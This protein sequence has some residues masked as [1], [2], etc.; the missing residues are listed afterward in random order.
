M[1][2]VSQKKS[3]HDI[4]F[5]F[6]KMIGGALTDT[7]KVEMINKICKKINTKFFVLEQKYSIRIKLKPLDTKFC[8]RTNPVISVP[9][10]LTVDNPHYGIPPTP[11]ITTVAVQQPT[12]VPVPVSVPFGI[13]TRGPFGMGSVGIGMVPSMGF[14]LGYIPPTD[15]Y[16]SKLCEMADRVQIYTKIK[17]YLEGLYPLGSL[18]TSPSTRVPFSSPPPTTTSPPRDPTIERYFERVVERNDV[19]SSEFSL[20]DLDAYDSS[21]KIKGKIESTSP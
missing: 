11:I 2:K 20:D 21:D 9:S 13:R 5:D 12:L 14:G 18:T 7:Q 15:G 3:T 16:E 1:R 8:L 4:G 19:D 10:I 6:K 17:A